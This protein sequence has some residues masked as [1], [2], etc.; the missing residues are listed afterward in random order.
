MNPYDDDDDL[1]PRVPR[2]FDATWISEMTEVYQKAAKA[3]SKAWLRWYTLG[4][5]R[6][7]IEIADDVAGIWRDWM[8]DMTDVVGGWSP[9]S[10]W[11]DGD[12]VP[13]LSF[14]IPRQTNTAGPK[15]LPLTVAVED[16]LEVSVTDL[17]GLGHDGRIDSRHVR[18]RIDPYRQTVQVL[19]TDLLPDN[20]IPGAEYLGC[21]YLEKDRQSMVMIHV[22][23]L[24]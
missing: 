1:N 15:E 7:P 19:L 5:G 16:Y 22:L 20:L 24:P 21:A 9:W 17:K 6:P 3:H 14:V 18:A 12:N 23:I 2:F 8:T 4:W 13:T 11:L 10:R